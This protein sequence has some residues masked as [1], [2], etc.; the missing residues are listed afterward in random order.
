[1]CNLYTSTTNQ[2]AMRRLYRVEPHQDKLG[3]YEPLT[4]IWP[5]YEAPVVRLDDD[6]ARELTLMSWGFLTP[7]VSKAT[8]K[9][10]K[11]DAWNNVRADKIAKS[12]LWKSSFHDRRCLIPATAYAEATGRNP[13]TYHWFG[14]EGVEGFA[15]A[16][17]WKHQKET[18]GDTEVDMLVHSMVT[19]NASKFASQYH[20]RMPVILDP[21]NYETWLSGPADAALGLLKP[22]ESDLFRLGGGIG[23]T[24]WPPD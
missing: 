6:G 5:K 11:P 15:L 9:A 13:A 1:M 18:V 7:K 2:E 17:I 12:G 22:W 16:G 21:S 20:N 19:T 24:K 23:V 10:L 8:G 14:L 3:N 4:S